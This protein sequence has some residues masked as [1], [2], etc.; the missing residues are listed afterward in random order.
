MSMKFTPVGAT[1]GH[2]QI[3]SG[4]PIEIDTAGNLSV[5]GS[6]DTGGNI[7]SPPA[8]EAGDAV[9]YEQ[10]FGVGQDWQLLTGSRTYGATYTNSTGRSIV[11]RIRFQASVAGFG[12][13]IIQVD[14]VDLFGDSTTDGNEYSTVEAIVPPGSTYRAANSGVA[15]NINRWQEYR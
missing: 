4:L 7:K 15:M 10:A 2:L 13:P 6:I 12:W 1:K 3:G 8:T 9:V 14:G 11:V 5:P